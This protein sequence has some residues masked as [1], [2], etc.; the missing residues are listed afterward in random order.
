[1]G[2]PNEMYSDNLATLQGT[3]MENVPASQ[4]Y[5]SARRAQLRQVCTEEKLVRFLKVATDDNPVDLFTKPLEG[6]SSS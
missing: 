2:E 3:Q 5:L 4:R 1:M 6:I